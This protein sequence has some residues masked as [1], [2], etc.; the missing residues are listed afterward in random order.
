MR[1]ST[2]VK[3]KKPEIGT[4]HLKIQVLDSAKANWGQKEVY[5]LLAQSMPVIEKFL[6]SNKTKIEKKNNPIIELDLHFIGDAKM[7]TINNM[8]RGK[9]KTTDV[10]SFPGFQ[11]LRS[12]KKSDIYPGPIQLGDILISRKVA[13]KQ[14][15]EFKITLSEEI[16]HLFVHGVLHLLGFDH[17]IS[18]KE[19]IIME[20][21][22]KELLLKISKNK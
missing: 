18:K 4:K 5:N 19:E 16:I 10:L 12:D 22:E 13:L 3:S 8:Y 20:A 11:S 9:G 7:K 6:Y 17:E 15:R 14:A 1:S 21:L 2:L